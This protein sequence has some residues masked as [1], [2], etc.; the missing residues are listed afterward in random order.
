MSRDFLVTDVVTNDL[1]NDNKNCLDS[2]TSTLKWIDR[3]TDCHVSRPHRPTE[4]LEST[5]I[6][7]C[8]VLQPFESFCYIPEKDDWYHFPTFECQEHRFC[9]RTESA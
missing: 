4:V 5:V 7:A 2:V 6:V 3:A 1:V 8:G 9:G